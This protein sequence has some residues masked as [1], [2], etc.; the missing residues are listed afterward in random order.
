[1]K[2]LNYIAIGLACVL[3]SVQ[4]SASDR[5]STRH[6]HDRSYISISTYSPWLDSGYIRY[7][8]DWGRVYRQPE[9]V[10]IY[11]SAPSRRYEPFGVFH[12]N[13]RVKSSRYYRDR[14]YSDRHHEY[15]HD[16]HRRDSRNDRGRRNHYK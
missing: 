2:I 11:R 5:Y 1:M 14:G 15:R 16:S 9:R 3:L 4:A 7:S 13:R 12:D 8:R 10:I 6:H